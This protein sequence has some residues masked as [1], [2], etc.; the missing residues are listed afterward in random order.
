MTGTGAASAI[1][2]FD[3]RVDADPVQVRMT[4]NGLPF[5]DDELLYA[6]EARCQCGAG[7][8]HPYACTGLTGAWWCSELLKTTRQPAAGHDTP[9]PFAGSG[10]VSEAQV[11]ATGGQVVTTRPP[12]AAWS[13]LMQDVAAKAEVDLA[14]VA[15]VDP[16]QALAQKPV[17]LETAIGPTPAPSPLAIG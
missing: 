7:L 13:L 15:R 9:L 8:A 2:E 5:T 16:M 14:V 10:I 11:H 3:A 6:A 4:G 17:V 1:R 12:T